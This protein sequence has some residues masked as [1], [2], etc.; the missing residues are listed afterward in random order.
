MPCRNLDSR[1]IEN[2][3]VCASKSGIQ[4]RALTVEHVILMY[5]RNDYT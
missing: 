2:N 5:S 4:F 3:L 1:M